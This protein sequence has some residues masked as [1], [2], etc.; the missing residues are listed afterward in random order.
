MVSSHI[1]KSLIV[2]LKDYDVADFFAKPVSLEKL[3]KKIQDIITQKKKSVPVLASKLPLQKD[4]YSQNSL[5]LITENK[6]VLKD[7]LTFIPGEFIEKHGLRIIAKTGLHDSINALKKPVNNIQM[8]IVDAANEAKI[9][10]L[11]KLLK[12]VTSKIQIVVY[13]I[14]T[15]FTSKLKDSLSEHGFENLIPR[16]N[17]TTENYNLL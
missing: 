16:G 4:P 2:S 11:I 13:F 14:A 6:E 5:L 10:V 9:M 8:I 1:N 15:T 3:E 7:P 12:I 17:Y